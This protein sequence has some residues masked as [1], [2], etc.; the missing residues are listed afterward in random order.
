MNET[1]DSLVAVKAEARKTAYAARK[2]AKAADLNAGGAAAA[3]AADRFLASVSV[4]A[5][6]IV[7]GYRPIRTEIDP[8][9]LMRALVERGARLCAPVIEAAE[10]PLLFRAWTPETPM[11]EGAFGA[12]VPAEGDW[13]EPTLLIAPLLAFDRSLYRLGYGGGFYDRTLEK[14]R[15]SR[16]T[17]AIGY[18]YAAQEVAAAPRGPTDQPL[19]GIVTETEMIAAR[20]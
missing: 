16:P 8:T 5:D 19:D 11:I 1:S 13:L 10:Q 7:A 2:A 6:D 17:R 18:A 3:A 9:P 15:A 14:L 4:A 12:E 20:D